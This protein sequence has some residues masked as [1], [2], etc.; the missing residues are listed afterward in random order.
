M[1][2]EC[3][4]VLRHICQKYDN[5]NPGVVFFQPDIWYA[6]QKKFNSLAMHEEVALVNSILGK[7][8]LPTSNI[9]DIDALLND[10]SFDNFQNQI[11][12][13]RHQNKLTPKMIANIS[14]TLIKKL[15]TTSCLRNILFQVCCNMRFFVKIDDNK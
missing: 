2:F 3:V 8:N 9:S 13:L 5:L 7:M 14:L 12:L 11:V 10:D 15:E 4:N 1:R 6:V